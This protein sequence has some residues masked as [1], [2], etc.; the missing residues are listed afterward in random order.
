MA[1]AAVT[2]LRGEDVL[3]GL[4][5]VINTAPVTDAQAAAAVQQLTAWSAAGAPRRET[6]AG[7]HT[8]G[9]ATAVRVM[10]AWWPLLVAGEFRP[11][12]GGDLY[13]ALTVNLGIDES[14]S[15][16]HGPTGAHAGR[17]FQFGWWSYVDK[18]LRQ[19]LGR[20]VRGPLARTY[21]GDGQLAA[22]RDMLLATLEQAAATP[23]TTVYP[24]DGGG[25]PAGDQWC[26]DSIVQRPLGGVTDERISWQNRPTYQQVVEFASHR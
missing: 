15:A 10:D 18:D 21:C 2:D 5:D 20:P 19:V 25:C 3:P 4:L 26:A 8:Y 14:P 12:L 1:D 6:A 11:G 16:G 24:G 17:S 22:C 23:A 9:D 7:S 13:G